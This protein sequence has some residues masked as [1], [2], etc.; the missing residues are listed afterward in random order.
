MKVF[1]EFEN[2]VNFV[3]D[4]DV[5]VGYDLGQ[6]WC[7]HAGWFIQDKIE[8]DTET[9]SLFCDLTKYIFDKDFYE[10]IQDGDGG[11][12]AIFKLTAPNNKPDLY[13]HLF[14]VHNGYY[15]HGF[16]VKHNGVIVKGGYL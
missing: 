14:N 3:D 9:N 8:K 7:E 1:E 16:T 2:K 11:G 6:D 15:G 4:N 5:Y 13:L 12:T 10:E